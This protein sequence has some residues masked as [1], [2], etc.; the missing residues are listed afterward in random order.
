MS[1]RGSGSKID[2]DDEERDEEEKNHRE[3]VDKAP[4]I[5]FGRNIPVI[6]Q[7]FRSFPI[8]VLI[9]C[10]GGFSDRIRVWSGSGVLKISDLVL[11]KARI[12]IKIISCIII[13]YR[14]K[15]YGSKNN[16][17]SIFSESSKAEPES[18]TPGNNHH[19]ERILYMSLIPAP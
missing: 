19:K 12:W 18:T 16:F 3:S 5:Q 7:G 6:L 17:R 11:G 13:I 15:C 1:S 10:F 8:L 14:P 9:R 2:E 4:E